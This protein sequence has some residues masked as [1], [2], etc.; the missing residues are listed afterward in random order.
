MTPIITPA[1]QRVLL[2]TGGLVFAVGNLVHPLEHSTSAEQTGT[3]VLAH[4]LLYA[5]VFGLAAGLPVLRSALAPAGSVGTVGLVGFWAG[6]LS[7]L[8]STVY[9]AFI[10][11]QLDGALEAD[12]VAA[13]LPS[14][15]IALP[16]FVGGG[17]LLGIAA[18]RA[19]LPRW[20]GITWI[21]ATIAL[22]VGPAVVSPEGLTIIPATAAQGLTVAGLA[23]RHVAVDRG[24]VAEPDPL[25]VPA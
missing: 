2:I 9:E 14:E 17:L 7:I 21:A 5:S 18:L 3:W 22:L 19:G 6:T 23:W 12:V 15:L 13:M 4:M 24:P 8:P 10:A 16:L 25:P 11:P 20:F 1:R